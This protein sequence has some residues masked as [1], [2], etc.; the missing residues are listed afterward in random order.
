M[1]S[2]TAFVDNLIERTIAMPISRTCARTIATISLLALGTAAMGCAEEGTA[3]DTVTS[4]LTGQLPVAFQ[5]S[6]NVLW[7]D[8]NGPGSAV[9]TGLSML[10]GTVPSQVTLPSGALEIGFQGSNGHFW[11]DQFMGSATDSGGTMQAGTS[12]SITFLNGMVAFGMHGVNGHLWISL[13]GPFN[14]FDTTAAM[15]SGTSP[16]VAALPNGQLALAFQ[17]SN[18][19]FWY[20]VAGPNS[21]QDSGGVM[22]AGTSPSIAATASSQ[23]PFAFHGSNGDLWV[24]LGG[25]HSGVDTGFS[26][27]AGTSPSVAVAN[28]VVVAFQA[29]NG[30]LWLYIN[31]GF[32]STVN[33]GLA[34]SGRPPSIIPTSSGGYQISF[35]GSNGDLS[36]DLNGTS[37]DQGYAMN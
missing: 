21:G 32:I 26:M 34:M 27:L 36:I 15:A 37:Q 24:G 2:P 18:G 35:K 5:R 13:A 6:T 9:S 22:A 33:T 17:G 23:V 30:S 28:G 20:G 3:D 29:G 25:L 11:L 19:H 14:G 8:Q 4:A 10:S 31:N 12:P 16:S 1:L 7:V